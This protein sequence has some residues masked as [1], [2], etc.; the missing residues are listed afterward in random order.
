MNHTF[1]RAQ[2]SILYSRLAHCCTH[3]STEERTNRRREQ[4]VKQ[5]DHGT[6]RKAHGS[7]P[8]SSLICGY[9]DRISRR[10]DACGSSV[11]DQKKSVA[12]TPSSASIPAPI[13]PSLPLAPRMAVVRCWTDAAAMARGAGSGWRPN[14]GRWIRRLLVTRAARILCA[15]FDESICRPMDGWR[16][17]AAEGWEIVYLFQ[18]IRRWRRA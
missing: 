12:I 16:C 7:G 6:L 1:Q 13:A 11:Y 18:G 2:S 8:K 4:S 14:A 5:E 10:R 15:I 17:A 9:L 3:K